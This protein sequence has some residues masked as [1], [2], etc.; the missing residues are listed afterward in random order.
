MSTS[1]WS[2]WTPSSYFALIFTCI[3]PTTCL[4]VLTAI[5]LGFSSSS[6]E[7]EKSLSAGNRLS[8]SWH[9]KKKKIGQASRGAFQNLRVGRQLHLSKGLELRN[10]SPSG[11]REYFSS[12]AFLCFLVRVCFTLRIGYPVS[13][14]LLED[15]HATASPSF[16]ENSPVPFSKLH[17]GSGIYLW[18]NYLWP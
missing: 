8:W 9:K 17:F 11:P 15:G 3:T 4:V 6:I 16:K 12:A 2:S 5:L 13:G 1:N 14:H 7:P 18:F 10:G